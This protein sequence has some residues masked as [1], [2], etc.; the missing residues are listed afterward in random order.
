[1]YYLSFFVNDS[2]KLEMFS[3]LGSL[4]EANEM[5]VKETI[6]RTQFNSG[7]YVAVKDKVLR[8]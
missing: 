6:I 8:S 1:M 3:M 7:D 5:L 4:K 2:I